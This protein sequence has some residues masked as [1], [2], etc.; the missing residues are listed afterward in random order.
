MRVFGVAIQSR[1]VTRVRERA[2]WIDGVAGVMAKLRHVV[3]EK[4]RVRRDS[5]R[6]LFQESEAFFFVGDATQVPPPRAREVTPLEAPP[7]A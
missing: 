1:K 4:Y 3:Q 6:G 5:S 7:E 2:F